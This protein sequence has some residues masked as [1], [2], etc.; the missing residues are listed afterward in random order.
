MKAYVLLSHTVLGSEDTAAIKPDRNPC[1]L[2][3]GRE[4]R[5]EHTCQ[6]IGAP[7]KR[8][9]GEHTV[10]GRA[11]GRMWGQQKVQKEV[12]EQVREVNVLDG[13][14]KAYQER[15]WKALK[16][17]NKT[18]QRKMTKRPHAP[19]RLAE[20]VLDSVMVFELLFNSV[21]SRKQWWCKWLQCVE[22]QMNFVWCTDCP[23]NRSDLHSW[24]PLYV[25][26]FWIFLGIG[27]WHLAS[28]LVN[29]WLK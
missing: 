7:R 8:K 6:I 14:S 16:C 24:L 29:L 18:D 25:S 19:S 2:E 12:G 28:S 20:T 15:L 26:A 22:K 5:G 17:E 9:Q 10:S 11:M 21:S 1:S 27:F 13:K 23:V 3:K 4:K